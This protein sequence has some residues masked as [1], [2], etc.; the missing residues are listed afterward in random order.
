LLIHLQ[1]EYEDAPRLYASA[2]QVDIRNIDPSLLAT[3]TERQS[4][5][6]GERQVW[7]SLFVP[8]F[9]KLPRHEQ[10][11]W[12]KTSESQ[13]NDSSLIEVIE[14]KNKRK[15]LVIENHV[16]TNSFEDNTSRLES[17]FTI[18]CLV[19]K[20]EHLDEFVK[21]V[22]PKV[23]E[24]RG[25]M[26]TLEWASDTF[27][28]EYAL[29]KQDLSS[30]WRSMMSSLGF[31]HNVLPTT[32]DYWASRSEGDYSLEDNVSLSL[33]APW[34]VAKMECKL[35]NGRELRFETND[36]N[37]VCFDPTTIEKGPKAT[38]VDRDHFVKSLANSGLA[39]VWIVHGEKSG[40]G[41]KE[42]DFVG[43]RFHSCLYS[44]DSSGV[45]VRHEEVISFE[46]PVRAT[47]GN[48]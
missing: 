46:W 45:L 13:L 24:L 33:P 21:T 26:P 15:W 17:W 23:K 9:R 40:Y 10:A 29:N 36:G 12:L 30:Q 18:E 16:S 48:S 22:S 47:A 3:K 5:G 41:D 19:V 39:P 42:D 2:S 14:P 32:V 37:V 31:Q 20:I 34:L 25:W 38:L 43:R 4:W 1:G 6:G 27:L 11:E 28:G 35:A 7:W 8:K 44:V